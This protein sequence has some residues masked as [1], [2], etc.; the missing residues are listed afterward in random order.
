MFSTHNCYHLSRIVCLFYLSSVSFSTCL[1]VVIPPRR[2]YRWIFCNFKQIYVWWVIYRYI[3]I[4]INSF[5]EKHSVWRAE[6]PANVLVLWC[7]VVWAMQGFLQWIEVYSWP[8]EIFICLS[9]SQVVATPSNEKEIDTIIGFLARK[10]VAK[11]FSVRYRARRCLSSLLQSTSKQPD[12]HVSLPPSPREHK[13]AEAASGV[14]SRWPVHST[15][16]AVFHHSK[17]PTGGSS[18]HVSPGISPGLAVATSTAERTRAAL[19]GPGVEDYTAWLTSLESLQ[20]SSRLISVL[21]PSIQVAIQQ[22]T[23]ISVVRI[24]SFLLNV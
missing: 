19:Q 7:P 9:H 21:L 5:V 24:L 2:S 1:R 4:L 10:L 13:R 15:D 3:I 6:G 22:E 14:T 11:Q 23:S 12:V 18:L 16:T 17:K 20:T 8:S